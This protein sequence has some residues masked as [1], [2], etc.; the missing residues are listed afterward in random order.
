MNKHTDTHTHTHTHTHTRTHTHTHTHTQTN[1]Q[2]N[3]HTHTHTHTHIGGFEQADLARDRR[4]VRSSIR[5]VVNAA[6]ESS[7]LHSASS[8]DQH[9]AGPPLDA[10]LKRASFALG[11]AGNAVEGTNASGGGSS[12][13]EGGEGDGTSGSKGQV[14]AGTEASTA[15]YDEWILLLADVARAVRDGSLPLQIDL[16][17]SEGMLHK[18]F[19]R[20][21]FAQLGWI[22]CAT[23]LF[24]FVFLRFCL[25]VCFLTI[26]FV[27]L[28]SYDSV[29]LF[30]FLRFCLFVCFLT[31]LFVWFFRA[32]CS[33]RFPRLLSRPNGWLAR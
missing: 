17:C 29:C 4:Q 28:L 33:R 32:R 2:T 11:S 8:D 7:L 5:A 24:G 10:L 6:A 12:A 25:F 19:G 31:I 26:L 14:K 27:C 16:D 13:G 15:I 22:N 18:P 21:L 20:F 1:K 23:L 30:A 3:T 9:D